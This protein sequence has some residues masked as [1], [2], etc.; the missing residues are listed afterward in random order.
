MPPSLKFI[1]FVNPAPI[2]E[3][4]QGKKQK[5]KLKSQTPEKKQMEEK[6]DDLT[7]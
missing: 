7:I 4:V 3:Q 1:K 6:M 2:D 5:K